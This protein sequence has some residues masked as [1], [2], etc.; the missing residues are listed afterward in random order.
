[1]GLIAVV[2]M[3]VFIIVTFSQA[4]HVGPIKRLFF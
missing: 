1:M 2:E 3:S 4:V